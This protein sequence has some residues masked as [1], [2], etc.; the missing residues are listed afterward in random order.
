MCRSG[1][2]VRAGGAADTV[3][4]EGRT[5][6]LVVADDGENSVDDLVAGVGVPGGGFGDTDVAGLLTATAVAR[7]PTGRPLEAD[8]GLRAL[9]QPASP[10]AMTRP[11]ARNARRE[12]L[13]CIE[14][15]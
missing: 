14:E 15:L 9:E 1:V 10:A 11:A 8:R 6:R 5:K 7:L 13:L 2:V 3:D 4:R 12:V